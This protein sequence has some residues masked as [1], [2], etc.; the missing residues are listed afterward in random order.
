MWVR[1]GGHFRAGDIL[2]EGRFVGWTFYS[3]GRYVAG[4]FVLALFVYM[5]RHVYYKKHVYNC[6]QINT[7]F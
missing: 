2:W 3:E 7:Q 5:V 6:L 4:R 1:T